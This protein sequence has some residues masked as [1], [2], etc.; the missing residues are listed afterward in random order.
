MRDLDV[1][2]VASRHCREV[3]GVID[4]LRARALRVRRFAP[5][6]FPEFD[7]LSWRSDERC[8]AFG[9]TRAAWLVDFSGWSVE[10]SLTGLAREVAIAE[11]IAFVDGAL[12][13]LDTQWLNSPIAIRSASRKLLQL[14]R[15]ADLGIRTPRTCVTNSQDV[16]RHFVSEVGRAVVKPL[17]ASYLNYGAKSVKFYTRDVVQRSEEI[18]SALASS[19]LIFQER[20]DKREEVRVTVVDDWAVG[21]RVDLSKAKIPPPVDIRQL[22]YAA[23]RELFGKCDDRSDLIEDSR[24]I[25][26]ELGLSYAGIDWAIGGDGQAYFLECNPLGSFKWFEICAQENITGHLVDALALRCGLTG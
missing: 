25:V 11:T 12:L 8:G 3:D 4:G 7:L 19:P 26:R 13:A 24:R 5:C 15:A 21:V 14:R 17:A 16:A 22:D 10:S 6:Q 18:F 20:I 23:H 9:L 2:V 1:L